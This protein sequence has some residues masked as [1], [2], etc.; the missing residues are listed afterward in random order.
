VAGH[1]L[2]PAVAGSP[3]DSYVGELASL[4]RGPRRR[5]ERI[6]AE[7]RDG[8]HDAVEG[9]V[10]GGMP[11]AQAEKDAIAE[12]G[13]P[14]AVAEAFAG[15]LTTAYARRV[16]AAYVATGPL[17]GIWWLLL[18]QPHPW[19]TGLVAL[20]LAIPALPLVAV[21]IATAT[22][23]LATTGRLIRWLPEAGPRRALTAVSGIAG[24][25][26]AVDAAMIVIYA[27]SAIP[28]QPLAVAAIAASVARIGY[29]VSTL[30]RAARMRRTLASTPRG[31]NLHE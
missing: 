30:R 5:R 20:M 16:I 1:R 2:N 21:A 11:E 14:R 24:L 23:T 31:G 8:L 7:F 28:L 27:R 10:A 4:L 15:E 26:L 9:R 6:L 18:L 12:F 25:V 17:V 19:R 3:I 29:G 22:A 13:T